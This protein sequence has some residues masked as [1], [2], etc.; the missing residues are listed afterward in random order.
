MQFPTPDSLL[1]WLHQSRIPEVSDVFGLDRE[2]GGGW[3][4]LMRGGFL[5]EAEELSRAMVADAPLFESEIAA[6]PRAPM[7]AEAP[8]APAAEPAP[9]PAAEPPAPPQRPRR[10][11][12]PKRT[13]GSRST[14]RAKSA[15][16]APP[17][18]VLAH[19]SGEMPATTRKGDIAVVEARLSRTKRT[20]APGMAFAT[21]AIRVVEDAPV[22]VSISARG[23]RLV[24]GGRRV[25]K[26]RLT[27]DRTTVRFALEAVD[28][29]AGEVTLVFRQRDEFP[30]ATLRLVSLITEQEA[31]DDRVTAESDAVE[32]EAD[33]R[34]L[35]TLRIDE[36]VADGTS[37]LDVAV[38]IGSSRV[39]GRVRTVD[40]AGLISK[41]YAQIADLRAARRSAEDG[42]DAETRRTRALARCVASV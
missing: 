16:P 31:D 2:V 24:K 27:A 38:Q 15:A 23:Y 11:E 25:R 34:K 29:G 3:S 8:A 28:P 12:Q 14:R 9:A 4:D 26:L 32:P 41:V 19:V 10:A 42:E 37:Y 20:A 7:E 6:A 35:P 36:S 40:K 39:E 17:P 22:S 21:A 18:D 30:L 1:S 13:G 33:L 5:V